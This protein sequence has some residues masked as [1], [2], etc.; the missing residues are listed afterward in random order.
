MIY[1]TEYQVNGQMFNVEQLLNN[2]DCN[3]RRVLLANMYR[4]YNNIR[5]V[6]GGRKCQQPIVD[7]VK[8][9]LEDPAQRE[10]V[11]VTLNYSDKQIDL[12]VFVA[13]NELDFVR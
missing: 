6:L 8:L 5:N 3:E 13:E 10:K 9:M 4:Q 1:P 7:K 2:A 12:I 11:R